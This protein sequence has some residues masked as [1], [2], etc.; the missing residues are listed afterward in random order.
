[1]YVIGN[2]IFMPEQGAKTLLMLWIAGHDIDEA[3]MAGCLRAQSAEQCSVFRQAVRQRYTEL[4]GRSEHFVVQGQTYPARWLAGLVQMLRALGKQIVGA[5]QPE[6]G[7]AFAQQTQAPD[8][9]LRRDRQVDQVAARVQGMA[10][11][12]QVHLVLVT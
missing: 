3:V 9:L 7:L 11:Q 8:L 6:G 2:A 5:I 4:R 12:L 10:L 1:G